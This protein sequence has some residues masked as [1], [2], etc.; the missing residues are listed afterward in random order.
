MTKQ[1]PRERLEDD[2]SNP[3]KSQAASGTSAT[4]PETLTAHDTLEECL[5][6]GV[7]VPIDEGT[8]GQGDVEPEAENGSFVPPLTVALPPRS[9]WFSVVWLLIACVALWGIGSATVN[10]VD[11]WRENLVLALPLILASAVLLGFLARA[12]WHEWA[13]MR[14]VDELAERRERVEAALQNG[15]IDDLKDALRPTLD[16]LQARDPA[17][18]NEFQAAVVDLDDCS[19]YL[20]CL[21]NIVLHSLDA[22]AKQVVKNGAIATGTAVAIVPHP[23]FDAI[24]V[25][26]RALVMTRRIGSI[27]GL[28][29][30]GLS[31]WRLL[32]HTLKSALL[33]AS[34]ET[35]T[36]LLADSFA[37]T[38]ARSVKP[39]A[40]G[41]VI[42]V[43]IYH[44]GRLTVSVCRPVRSQQGG[45]Q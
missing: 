6:E 7:T 24:V 13:A 25:L 23:A 9:P 10:L 17:L 43:R 4:V 3:P 21:E 37:T 22:E 2:E 38:L 36:T 15:N 5:V 8:E 32:S 29:P 30:G 27:Y 45:L 20:R 26:W 34:M 12:L 39:V 40:E 44:L 28:R 19:D 16:N 18:I 42:A 1:T 41:A 11:L 35:L 14:D 31:S 33:A